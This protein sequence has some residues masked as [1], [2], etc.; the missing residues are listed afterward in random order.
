V[1]GDL[2]AGALAL[3]LPGAVVGLLGVVGVE[4]DPWWEG[5]WTLPGPVVF[6]GLEGVDVVP[7]PEVEVEPEPEPEPWLE[8][9]PPFRP[10]PEPPLGGGVVVVVVVVV[11]GVLTVGTDTGGGGLAGH[12]SDI[13]AAGAGRFSEDSGAPGGS[14]KYRTWPVSNFTVTVQSVL[15]ATEAVGSAATPATANKMPSVTS[16]TFSFPRPN[17]V[18]FSPPD[19]K[20]TSANPRQVP[21]E[22]ASRASY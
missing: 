1:T 5:F 6:G 9:P 8:P 10:P 14:W 19:G 17:T 13:L 15:E 2:G 12:D 22:G 20:R 3:G 4:V 21:T 18:A 16:A 11:D 7:D